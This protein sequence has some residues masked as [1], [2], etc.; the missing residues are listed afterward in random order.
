M[1]VQIIQLALGL[2]SL[3]LLVKLMALN[4]CLRH[5]RLPELLVSAFLSLF[6]FFFVVILMYLLVREFIQPDML[7]SVSCV[8]IVSTL[9]CGNPYKNQ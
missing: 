6:F 4:R 2:Y 9:F 7:L 1:T 8:H 3:F 5:L